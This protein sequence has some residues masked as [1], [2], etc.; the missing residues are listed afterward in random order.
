[1]HIKKHVSFVSLRDKLSARFLEI[2][3]WRNRESVQ[4]EIH[5]VLMS[6]FAMMYFQD[7]S[8]LEFQKRF[9]EGLQRNNLG[10]L[11]GVKEIPKDTQMREIIDEIDSKELES[12][13]MDFFR[14]LQRGRFACLS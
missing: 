11:F 12:L 4:Y 5:D 13:F 7:P 1:M 2:P 9:Q 14:P 6:G 3:D 10:T 8:I